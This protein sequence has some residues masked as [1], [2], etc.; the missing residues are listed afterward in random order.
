MFI[1][2]LGALLLIGSPGLWNEN[3]GQALVGA[4]V[5]GGMIKIGN[6]MRKAK[7]AKASE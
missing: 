5:G 2:I 1:M 3:P 7:K 6:H 4:F